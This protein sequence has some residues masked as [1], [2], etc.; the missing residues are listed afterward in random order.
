MFQAIVGE[1]L[2]I[3]GLLGLLFF[4]LFLLSSTADH[5]FC[6]ALQLV[7]AQ[8]HVSPA[9]A[10]VTFLA[11]GNGISDVCSNLMA[12]VGHHNAHLGLS[13]ILGS[14][15]FVTTVVTSA[16]QLAS[17]RDDKEK[18]KPGDDQ[19]RQ[20]RTLICYLF[21]VCYLYGILHWNQGR[22]CILQ[23]L[24]FLVIYA[25]FVLMVIFWPN[26]HKELNSL[27]LEQCRILFEAQESAVLISPT[28]SSVGSTAGTHPWTRSFSARSPSSVS[29]TT[30]ISSW[31][32]GI[33]PS[34]EKD[35]HSGDFE[36]RPSRDISAST[37][38]SQLDE[39]S[40]IGEHVKLY[41]STP[42]SL[43][44]DDD[45]YHQDS[46]S[47]TFISTLKVIWKP[48]AKILWSLQRCTIP[49]LVTDED[50]V[51]NSCKNMYTFNCIAPFGASFLMALWLFGWPCSSLQVYL[52]TF[53]SGS[54]GLMYV[55]LTS[56]SHA[57][58][59][60]RAQVPYFILTCLMSITWM[61]QIATWIIWSLS[62][63]GAQCGFSCTVLGLTVLA[64]GNS[65]GDLVSNVTI[66]RDGFSNMALAGCFAGPVF[67]LNVG[68]G[69][70]L[71]IV[72]M[73]GGQKGI[74]DLGAL[75]TREHVAF[76]FLLASLLL[77]LGSMS[78][79]GL[80]YPRKIVGAFVGLYLAFISTE[81]MLSTMTS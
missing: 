22:V 47:R 26:T 8:G 45:D 50:L 44:L 39:E 68:I 70:S 79:W 7:V 60:G 72:T 37:L 19:H 58:P 55:T 62:N 80:L 57:R 2:P 36:I 30:S 51:T 33:I 20:T 38:D 41:G 40:L 53:I 25:G 15:V 17:F 54:L 18:L 56:S 21:S 77:H 74:V 61:M 11:F 23:A 6:P 59:Q 3:L 43:S 66:A 73:E 31:K 16:V 9:V 75:S 46:K 29:S 78:L 42:L 63:L 27:D 1:L 64:W 13:S 67:N 12:F 28:Q 69:L 34:I 71:L 35:D 65:L 14:G 5:F 32:A 48:L 52:W 10:G 76:G 24:G 49:V 81:L 4:L